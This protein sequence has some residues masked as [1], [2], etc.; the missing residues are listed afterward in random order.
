MADV[1]LV[2]GDTGPSIN[3]ALKLTATQLP[4]DLTNAAEIRFQMRQDNDR[5]YTVDE[6]AVV[7]DAEDGTVRY[8]WADGDLSVFGEYICQW[9][10]E[11]SDGTFQTT[12]PPNTLTVRRQ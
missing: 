8:D 1:T 4:L 2:Q 11:W 6:V 3:G 7:V 10:I 9:Q 12:E 5:H